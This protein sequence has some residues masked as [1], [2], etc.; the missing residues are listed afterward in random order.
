ML[1]KELKPGDT[2]ILSIDK[3][4]PKKEALFTPVFKKLRINLRTISDTNKVVTAIRMADGG[5]ATISDDTEVIK[6]CC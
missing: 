2:F 6:L 5:P 4:I 3:P 1:L